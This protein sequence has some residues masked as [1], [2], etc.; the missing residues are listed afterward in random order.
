MLAL[1]Y[2][3][4][5]VKRSPENPSVSKTS[6]YSDIIPSGSNPDPLV[7]RHAETIYLFSYTR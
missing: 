7:R 1:A 4:T 2:W 5:N 6:I 3:A